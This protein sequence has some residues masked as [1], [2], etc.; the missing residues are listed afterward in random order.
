MFRG[1]DAMKFLSE[2]PGKMAVVYGRCE[3]LRNGQLAFSCEELEH[4]PMADFVMVPALERVLRR[5]S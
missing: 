2:L 1:T 3:L 4:L 5:Y